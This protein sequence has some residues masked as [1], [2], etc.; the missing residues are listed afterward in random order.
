MGF[1]PTCRLGSSAPGAG[2]LG[3]G[4]AHDAENTFG[5][6]GVFL[7]LPVEHADQDEIRTAI[8]RVRKRGARLQPAG[9]KDLEGYERLIDL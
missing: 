5:K 3:I 9:G 1:Y 6:L 8:E 2:P 7:D 4:T